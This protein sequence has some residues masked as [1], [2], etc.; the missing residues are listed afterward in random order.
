MPLVV[1]RCDANSEVGIGHV[2]RCIT[3]ASQLCR[4][5]WQSL[6]ICETGTLK[7][8]PFLKD[9]THDVVEHDF[10]NVQEIAT[11]VLNEK[12][13]PADLFVIDH[14]AI[15][16][17]FESVLRANGAKIMVIDDL[18]NR[19]HACDLL[20]DQTFGRLASDYEKY[21]PSG[22]KIITGS[23]FALVR[24]EF[25]KLR[26]QS[27]ELRRSRIAKGIQSILITF[28][29]TDRTSLILEVLSGL[30]QS[31]HDFQVDVVL[32]NQTQLKTLEKNKLDY[33][34]LT[35]KLYC[36]VEDMAQMMLRADL[37]IAAGGTT[38]WERCCL[39]LPTFL[40]VLAPNQEKISENLNTVGA[41]VNLGSCEK[42]SASVL[43]DTL[44]NF[45]MEKQVA[46][47]NQA[48]KVCDGKGSETVV[49]YL[50]EMIL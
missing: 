5:G 6:F 13:H 10:I 48:Q 20:L 32:G 42:V 16:H 36:D 22:C 7:Q 47:I 38:S 9:N 37:A 45:S 24:P 14:Y 43:T 31:Q 27:V 12:G 49:S 44:K 41:V 40:V 39:G 23:S 33:Q 15:D 19:A 1:F 26:K 8:C 18:C 21:V 28:G 30:D 3:L 4:Q 50:N 25:S 11:I 46:M 34:Y 35:C 29:G 17:E 2:M